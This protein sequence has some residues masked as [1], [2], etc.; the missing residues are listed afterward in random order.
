MFFKREGSIS[1]PRVFIIFP[2][3]FSS[4]EGFHQAHQVFNGFCRFSTHFPA[5]F[6]G[7]ADNTVVNAASSYELP[8][9]LLECGEVPVNLTEARLLGKP[10][11]NGKIMGKA[12][13]KP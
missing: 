5:I 3:F 8:E 9:C 13:E 11:E 4:C 1:D 12:I 2:G 6:P 7:D 10:W